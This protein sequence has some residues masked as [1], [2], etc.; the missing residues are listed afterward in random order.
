M[1]KLMREPLVCFLVLGAGL[2]V[3]HHL[4]SGPGGGR[5]SNIVVTRGQVDQLISGFAKAW[6]RPPTS[7]E[8]AGLIRDRVREEVYCREATAMGLDKDDTIIRRRL[9]QKMEFVSDDVATVIAPTDADLIAYL[10]AHPDAFRLSGRFT[11]TH[12]YLQPAKHGEHLSRDAQ[13][14]LARLKQLGSRADVSLLGDAFL[15]ERQFTAVPYDEVAGQFGDPFAARLTTLSPGQWQGPVESGYGVHLVWL[16]QRTEPR[17][18]A[19]AEVRD[20][21]RREWDNARRLDANE[22]FYRELLKRYTVTVEGVS[23]EPVRLALG[24]SK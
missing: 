18:P 11:F 22:N 24:G 16:S 17:L 20:A 2:F 21:V 4:V 12:V 13:D 15:L 1:K 23:A 10:Q 7:E 14:L 19:L 5:P 9:R 8:L 3:V 6:Q